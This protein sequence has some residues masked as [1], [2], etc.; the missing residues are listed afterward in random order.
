MSSCKRGQKV[1]LLAG[2]VFL[3]VLF[4]R[5]LMKLLIIN[6][7]S[8]S[9]KMSIFED[10]RE[11]A[12]ESVFH[13]A[14]VLLQ[15]ENVNDQLPMRTQ[16]CMDFLKKHGLTPDDIDVFVGRGG[17][18]YPQRSGVCTIDETLVSDTIDTVGGSDHPAK[19][20]V[21][22]AW[23]LG[24]PLGKPMYTLDPT[25]IDELID[26]ARVTGINGLY[27]V[28]QLHALNHRAIAMNHSK[29]TGR[30]YKNSRYIVAHIDGGITVAAHENGR[31]IDTTEGAGGD[32]SFTP[33]RIGSI[34]LLELVKWLEK[35]HTTDEVRRMCSRS[36]GFVSHFGTSDSNKVHAMVEAGDPHAV[37]VW[38]T[39]I[40][41][42][43]KA[44]GEMAAVLSGKVDAILLTGGLLRFDDIVAGIRERC[45]F[46]APIFT[47]PGEAEQ[48]ALAHAVLRVLRG[49]EQAG[50]YTGEPVWNG[51]PWDKE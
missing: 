26:E 27:R 9:T 3:Y 49:E 6:P 19:L 18:A 2:V 34:P 44:I 48:E 7:G 28:S 35:G 17:G 21:L 16:C 10:A 24:H 4:G 39:L 23:E 22:I 46:I 51:F 32:G 31:I 36:G 42:T 43:A 25:N 37:L 33:T 11:I 45:S 13:D 8:T 29:L 5:K 41:Q 14:P 47:Y 38:N 12:T 30:D 40:Y 1:V 20:G 50:T 15:Y